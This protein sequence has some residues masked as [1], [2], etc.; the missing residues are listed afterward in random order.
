MKSKIFKITISILLL[1]TLTMSNFLLVGV[2]VYSYAVDSISTNNQNVEF[3][4]Y[5]KNERGDKTTTLESDFQS[6]QSLFLQINIKK[7]GYF[8]GNI[9]IDKNNFT[10]ESSESEYVNRIERNTIY[11]NQINAGI[12]TE[13]EIKVQPVKDEIYKAG[14]LDVSSKLKMNGIYRDSREKDIEIESTKEVILKLA[15]TNK[16][17]NIE[18]NVRA[19]TNK[20]ITIDGEE[21]RLV[22]LEVSLGLKSNTYPIK[23]IISEINIPEIKGEQPKVIKVVNFN[24]MTSYDYKY[25]GK[26]VS[27]T[28]DNKENSEGY[29]LWRNQGTEKIILNCIYNKNADVTNYEIISK[30][31]ITLYDNKEME[32]TEKFN[33]EEVNTDSII[34][35]DSSYSEESIYKG[36]IKAGIDR[37]IIENTKI[38]VNLSNVTN[39]LEIEETEKSILGI[40]YRETSINKEEFDEIFGETG[41]ITIKGETNEILATIDNSTSMNEEGNIVINYGENSPSV[42]K[43]ETTKPITEGELNFKHSK[44]I[45]A[46]NVENIKKVEEIDTQI[47]VTYNNDVKIINNSNPKIELKDTI[48]NAKLEVNKDTLSTIIANNVEI[49]ATLMGNSES[50]DLFKNPKLEITL[51]EEVESI[52]IDSINLLYENE[53]KIKNHQVNG[54]T[55]IVELEGAQTQY[56]ELAVEGANVVI[57]AIIN[58]NRKASTRDT[59]ISMKYI[60]QNA[61]S[62]VENGI[63]AKLI[64]VVA[65]KDMTTVHTINEFGI[66]TIGQEETAKVMLEKGSNEKTIT[67]KIEVINNNE[68][69]VQDVKIIGTFATKNNKNNIN[70]KITEGIVTS[71]NAKIYYTENE[72][73]T[74]DLQKV[75]NKWEETI[76]NNSNVKKYLIIIP[77]LETQESIEATYKMQIPGNL[78]YNQ[79]ATEGYS[80]NYINTATKVA[81]TLK[82]TNI[83][84]QTGIGPKIETKLNASLGGKELSEKTSV[85]NGEVIS[86]NVQISNTGTEDISNIVISANIPEGTTLVEPEEHYEYTG[87][88]Y[89]K[90]LETRTFEKTVETLKVGEVIKVFYEVRVNNNQQAGTILKSKAEVKYGEAVQETNELINITETGDVRVTVKRITDRSIDLYEAGTVQYFAIVENISNQTQNDIKIRTNLSENLSVERLTKYTGMTREEFEEDSLVQIGEENLIDPLGEVGELPE[91][92]ETQVKSEDLEYSDEINV[93]SIKAGENIVLSYSL[94]INKTDEE[95]NKIDFSVKAIN[96]NKEYSSNQLENEIAN[97]DINISMK[98]NTESRYIQAGDILIYTIEIKN[99]SSSETSG[100]VIKD[101]IPSALEIQKIVADGEELTKV[102]TNNLEIEARIAANGVG[103]IVIETLVNY[104]EA[105]TEA[106]AITNIATA[107]IYGEKVATTAEINHI[108]L[109]NGDSN[110]NGDNNEENNVEDNDVAT[111]T[112]TI[113]GTAWLDE[114]GNG[115]KDLDEK[116][117]KDITV[118]LLNVETNNFVKNKDGDILETT[119][120]ENGIYILDHI[121]NGKYIVVFEYNTSKYTLTKYQA[122]GTDTSKVIKNELVIEGETEQITSTDIIS[123]ENENI[124]DINIGL[125]ELQNFDF[126]LDKVVNRI[127]VQDANGSTVKEYDNA[128]MAKLE[129]DAKK[130]TGTTVIV[131]YAIKVSNIGEVDGY[132]K[133]IADYLPS[134][135]KFSSELNRDWYQLGDVAYTSS[136]A[137]EKIVTGE[138]KTLTLTLTKTMTEDNVGLINNTAEIIESYNDLGL[139]DSNSVAGNRT[140]GENDMGSADVILSIRTGGVVYV[141]ISIITVIAISGIVILIVKKKQKIGEI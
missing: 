57:N 113:Q 137:N 140:A 69:S 52:T 112:K 62:Y 53:L 85:K 40:K 35:I 5:F 119:T 81:T 28:F 23:Q 89:Y 25:D 65:P 61:I 121:G 10:L 33:I 84:L 76:L 39:S 70:T 15:N 95:K 101:Q 104:S 91:A 93:G 110:E 86:Y 94:L 31:K 135:L 74:D 124:S 63:L 96:G 30:E 134:D 131:E 21:K 68:N 75:E 138:S 133:K 126:K 132:V 105:R 36:K 34:Q 27:L 83:E 128:T 48:T 73:A 12:S 97:M 122:E 43:I 100:L 115:I 29:I 130:I 117:L 103:T 18:N 42:L 17:E 114:N 72:E 19:I 14:L 77:T 8:N 4:V 9:S 78:E 107:E 54:R 55:I 87:A 108:I 141:T 41:I 99:N 118:K 32:S 2:G 11:L 139:D 127:L 88:S 67:E 51:P 1:I 6:E 66:E 90:E 60:N 50:Y 20:V 129:L 47:V 136:L 79:I 22:Q 123:L 58:V 64:R 102:N 109:A 46:T 38:T 7:E 37:E 44:I 71:K 13:I 82:S 56:K 3:D 125:V 98:A 116:S 92:T 16:E 24:T 111:G 80:V 59:N 120:N 49:K 26:T 106:E 45:D